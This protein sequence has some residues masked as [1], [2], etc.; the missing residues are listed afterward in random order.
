MVDWTD[1]EKPHISSMPYD[2]SAE[3]DTLRSSFFRW[4]LQKAM[5]D[6]ES[7]QASASSAS[8]LQQQVSVLTSSLG[9]CQL[10]HV[11]C[12]RDGHRKNAYCEKN[13][14]KNTWVTPTETYAWSDSEQQRKPQSFIHA[15]GS[16]W[17]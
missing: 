14:K 13:E 11:Q 15:C 6:L 8:A 17:L 5:R 9:E 4:V 2:W 12:Q 10:P 16:Y 7:K 3:A 1:D